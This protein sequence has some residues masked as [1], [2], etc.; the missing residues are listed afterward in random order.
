MPNSQFHN[1]QSSPSITSYQNA[2]G[3]IDYKFTND[4]M[5][6]AILQKH[7]NVLKGL[8][9]SLL[10]LSPKSITDITITN[11]IELGKAIDNKE[12]VLDIAVRI[13]ND[14][15]LNLEMQ[16]AN[17]LNWEDRS[18]GYLCRAFDQLYRGQ[19]YS[20][21]LPVIHIGFLDFQLF[22]GHP[23]FYS[24]HKLLNVKDHHLFSDKLTLSVIDLT[25]IELA[26]KEDRDYQIDLWAKLFTA[27]TW[28]EIK[29]LADKNEYMQEATQALFECNADELIRQQCYAREEYDR[30]QRTINKALKD[31]TE[32]RDQLALKNAK[33]LETIQKQE[34]A[35]KKKDC[36]LKEKD[37]AIKEKDAE[38]AR[39]LALLEK[40]E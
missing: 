9:C 21:A 7:N 31:T 38:I 4:Y 19:P 39:L 36:D 5:F 24:I 26:T 30:Y 20:S 33:A 13:N 2:T 10:H 27:T 28:E 37:D 18:L 15:F 40:K 12:F 16:V 14:T 34:V 3:N 17:E 11:P 23:E 8:I 29:M 1:T 25:H 35:L 6:R 32:E 22:P